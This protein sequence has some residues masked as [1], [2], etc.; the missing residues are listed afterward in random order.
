MPSMPQA[1][2]SNCNPST[3][4][5]TTTLTPRSCDTALSAGPRFWAS[6]RKSRWWPCRRPPAGSGP[7]RGGQSWSPCMQCWTSCPEWTSPTPVATAALPWQRWRCG[8]RYGICTAWPVYS[9]WGALDVP[10]SFKKIK[11]INIF[12]WFHIPVN[13]NIAGKTWQHQKDTMIPLAMS[14][15]YHCGKFD[16][17]LCVS[18]GVCTGG[19]AWGGWGV[20]EAGIKV[21]SS[22]FEMVKP[23]IPPN[24]NTAWDNEVNREPITLKLALLPLCQ[25]LP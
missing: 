3:T 22:S 4:V 16:F 17:T 24:S 18:V 11:I 23:K 14:N 9:A 5:Y 1:T 13:G 10:L 2:A 7:C 8:Y 12:H 20:V 19:G 25:Q 21:P 15:K 6:C